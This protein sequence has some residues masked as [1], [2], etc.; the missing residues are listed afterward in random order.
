MT[1]LT[2]NQAIVERTAAPTSE[3]ASLGRNGP[4][5]ELRRVLAAVR[6]VVAVI[7]ALLMLDSPFAYRS[8]FSLGV[9]AFSI[10]AGALFFLELRG[11][12]LPDSRSIVWLDAAWCILL[13][14]LDERSPGAFSIFLF[15][16]V[17]FGT[18]RWGYKQGIAVAVISALGALLL[19]SLRSADISTARILALPL[20]LVLLGPLVA[21][22]ARSG[23]S[24]KQRLTLVN[25]LQEATDPRHGLAAVAGT[26]MERL[27]TELG[28]DTCLFALNLRGGG[29]YVL[30]CGSGMRAE[31]LRG[32]AAQVT[33]KQILSLPS[34]VAAVFNGEQKFRFLGGPR[35]HAFDLSSSSVTK[36]G[37]DDAAAL[38]E[39]IECRSFL[40]APVGRPNGLHGRMIIGANQRRFDVSNVDLLWNVLE[41][42]APV[43]ENAALLE[44]LAADA[45]EHE[46]SKIGRDLHDS[47]I[48]PYIGLKF[49]IEALARRVPPKDPLAEQI[50]R[51]VQM[52]SEEIEAL[53]ELVHGLR[54]GGQRGDGAL[55]PAVRRQAKRYADLFGIEVNVEVEG[56]P[57]LSRRLSGELFHIVAEGLSNIRRHT[58]ASKAT[59]NLASTGDS[60]VL[61]IS[62]DHSAN[63]APPRRFTPRS[64]TERTAAL[65]GTLQIDAGRAD[66]TQVIIRIPLEQ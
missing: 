47:A 22:L 57:P 61:R 42:L 54:S 6:V 48:Q 34:A 4:T 41:S 31:V 10:Y 3:W 44:R 23:V 18:L 43:M 26:V 21:A 27:S 39:L 7:A 16:P 9:L 11:D 24:L 40:A 63:E 14:Y 45:A 58:R 28:A 38:A 59:V 50:A 5:A 64:L 8:V 62:N 15:F 65:G 32:S 12:R 1:T 36:E 60:L 55:L 30:R 46:R 66:Q 56:D 29:L 37:E 53:R 51:L 35:Y 33:A 2:V 52:A 49:A 25:D 19:L 20:T 17:L 13:L